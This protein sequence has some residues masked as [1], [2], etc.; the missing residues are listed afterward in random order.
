MLN[1]ILNP[2]TIL[3]RSYLYKALNQKQDLSLIKRIISL[4]RKFEIILEK[5]RKREI[6]ELR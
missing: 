6:M 4:A 1:P 3:P 2:I 5:I